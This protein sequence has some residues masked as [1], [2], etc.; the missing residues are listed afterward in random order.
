MEP[1]FLSIAAAISIAIATL[2][3]APV[4]AASRTPAVCQGITAERASRLNRDYHGRGT[5]VRSA[6]EVTIQTPCGPVICRAG[7]G[8]AL[9]SNPLI[10]GERSG[11]VNYPRLCFW[12]AVSLL[13][14]PPIE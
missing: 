1:R 8:Y 3:T 9:P 10:D 13:I 14:D 6:G 7:G 4:P 2:V 11:S 12:A 5:L